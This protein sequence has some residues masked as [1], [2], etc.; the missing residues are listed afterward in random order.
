[1]SISCGIGA[2]S[3][4]RGLRRFSTS[5]HDGALNLQLLGNVAARVATAYIRKVMLYDVA[6][7]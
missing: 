1:M 4:P 5:T 7:G 6:R 2:G 3:R